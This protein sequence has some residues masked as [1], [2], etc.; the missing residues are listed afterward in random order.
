MEIKNVDD[1]RKKF[2]IA[3]KQ[4]LYIY[5]FYTLEDYFNHELCIVLQKLIILALVLRLCLMVHCI[6][7]H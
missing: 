5:S 1:N 4:F 3:L 7:I 2:E 6:S